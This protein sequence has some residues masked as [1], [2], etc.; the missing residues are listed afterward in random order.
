MA[1]RLKKWFP[2]LKRSIIGLL[3]VSCVIVLIWTGMVVWAFQ[4]KLQ[5]W[6]GFVFCA[7]F[8]LQVG[9]DIEKVRLMERLTRLGYEKTS[10]MIP[11]PGQ[12]TTR[13][14]ETR[15]FCRASPVAGQGIVSG[16][17]RI[18]LD[19]NRVV[20]IRLVRSEEEVDRVTLEPE[21]LDIIPAEGSPPELCRP[22]RLNAV[23]PL[24]VDAVIL[25]EDARFYSH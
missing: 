11:G 9:D 16:P 7:P 20:G 8:N 24:L 10:D 12:V 1:R 21:L 17:I 4:V 18:N 23:N 25:A 15:I 3:I 14:S 6:P 2:A 5:R 22:V 19:W 13:G